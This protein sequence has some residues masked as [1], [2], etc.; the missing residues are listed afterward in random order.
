MKKILTLLITLCVFL[1]NQYIGHKIQQHIPQT[2]GYTTQQQ[3]YPEGIPVYTGKPYTVLNKNIPEFTKNELHDHRI[4]KLSELDR[5]NRCGTALGYLGP[6][7]LP[8]EKRQ[9]IGM[10][11]PSGWQIAKYDIVN[12]RYIYHRSH[13]IAH[14]LSGINA[15]PRNLI[16]GTQYL[17]VTGMLPFENRT[18]DYIKQ[19]KNHVLYRVTPKFQSNN[20]VCHGVQIE[21][22]SI[23]DNGRL[24]FNVFIHNI[25]PGIEINYK[26]GKTKLK[27][28]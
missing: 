22:W 18:T 25:Q 23:E 6:E 7:T 12:Q 3:E 16:T 19:S 2:D 11:K 24:H 26:T 28:K 14:Q 27:K 9:P 8:T 20:L 17:N 4:I 15:D 21:A 10:L 13:L 5:L 1:W